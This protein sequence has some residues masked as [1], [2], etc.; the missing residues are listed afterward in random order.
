MNESV[1]AAGG[2]GADLRAVH[3]GGCGWGAGG[4]PPPGGRGRGGPRGVHVVY[5]TQETLPRGE[6]MPGDADRLP[7]TLQ[8]E[9]EEERLRLHRPVSTTKINGY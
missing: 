3:G 9:Q 1:P 8:G 6:G 4:R 7:V 2:A 5:R